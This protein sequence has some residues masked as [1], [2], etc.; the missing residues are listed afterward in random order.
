MRRTRSPWLTMTISE[1]LVFEY[2]G[3]LDKKTY[4]RLGVLCLHGL[5]DSHH[6]GDWSGKPAMTRFRPPPLPPVL[7]WLSTAWQVCEES[8]RWT[9]PGLVKRVIVWSLSVGLLEGVLV[10]AVRNLNVSISSEQ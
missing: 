1:M 7:S 2:P 6:D 9:A 3:L 10:A 5:D 8:P 4:E